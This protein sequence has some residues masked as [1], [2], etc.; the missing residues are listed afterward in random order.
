MTKVQQGFTLIE[1]MI[2]VAIIGILAA[3]AVPAY[4]DYTIRAKISEALGQAD[5]AKGT[6]AEFYQ[7]NN[8]YA[9]GGN[10]SY[11]LATSTSYSSKYVTSIAAAA[12]TGI[13]TVTVAGT[14]GTTGTIMLTPNIGAAGQVDWTCGGTVPTKY[15]PS[16]CRN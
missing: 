2:V 14:T 4:Q 3:I 1:L 8:R 5:M 16:S 7:T 13:I 9:T 12:N 15:R 10:T 11:G 6:V